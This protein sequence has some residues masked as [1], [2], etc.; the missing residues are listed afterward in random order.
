MKRT[1]F[2]SVSVVLV[3]STGL[4]ADVPAVRLYSAGSL[5]AAMTDI[6]AAYTSLYGATVRP[7]YGASGA[8]GDRLAK[9]EVGDVFTSADMGYPEALAKAGL[10]GPTVVFA[11][12]H[13]CAILRPGLSAAPRTVLSMLLKPGTK[14]GTSSPEIDPGG[15]YAWAMFKKADIAK[16]GSR[17]TLEAKALKMGSPDGP[18]S[19]PAET[20][21]ATVWL[22]PHNKFHGLLLY[23]F[24]NDTATTEIP[25]LSLHDALPIFARRQLSG[26]AR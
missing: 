9:G 20:P 24:F 5:R 2:I 11:R 15:A 19:V 14:V 3:S 25:P 16:P 10:S 7:V 18:L 26:L 21:N 13:L 4:A 17:A 6:A 22:F 23:F 1:W 8:L 12:N